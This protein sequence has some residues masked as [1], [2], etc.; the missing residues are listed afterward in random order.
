MLR[1]TGQIMSK[2]LTT[3]SE[4][5][6]IT[7]VNNFKCLLVTSGHQSPSLLQAECGQVEYVKWILNIFLLTF[8]DFCHVHTGVVEL[9]GSLKC[10]EKLSK[11][12]GVL[13][14]R[15]SWGLKDWRHGYCRRRRSRWA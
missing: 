7:V 6:L 1:L 9:Q 15:R 3:V 2:P 10:W 8:V 11:Q 12:G 14:E 5:K 13:E 4:Q